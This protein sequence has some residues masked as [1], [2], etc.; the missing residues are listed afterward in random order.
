MAA[1]GYPRCIMALRTSERYLFNGVEFT[2]VRPFMLGT[3]SNE[4]IIHSAYYE[5]EISTGEAGSESAKAQI[6]DV[7]KSLKL[8]VFDDHRAD[9]DR[10]A[11][12]GA[13]PSR[14]SYYYY[15][16]RLNKEA[17]IEVD[18]EHGG[19]ETIAK[20]RDLLTGKVDDIGKQG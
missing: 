10:Y 4:R 15:V 20:A 17:N 3:G 5:A 12:K 7:L 19:Y 6:F 11:T 1:V 18:L 13:I 14:G 9:A 16:D 2:L 8:T